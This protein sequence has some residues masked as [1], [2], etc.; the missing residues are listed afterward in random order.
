MN[1]LDGKVIAVTGASGIAAAAARRFASAGARVQLFSLHE[2]E[3]AAVAAEL[4]DGGTE[5]FWAAVD[6]TDGDATEAAFGEGR[7]RLG[8]L[9]GLFAVAGGSGRRFGDGPLHEASTEGWRTTMDLNGLP[10]FHA[11]RAAVR[12]M[13][14]EPGPGSIVLISSVLATDPSPRLFPTHAYAAAKGGTLSLVKAAASY[15]APNGIRFNAI[16]PGLVDTPMAARAATDPDTLEYAR[17]KQ[18]LAGGL[19]DPADIAAAAV[20]LLSD[21]SRMVTGQVLAV[22]GGWSVAEVG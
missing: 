12:I 22:D 13:L 21:D 2:A 20:F 8:R 14:E 7:A 10:A 18:P 5:T 3:A 4:A 1:S 11:A 6:L 19:L 17:R 16:A 15:Y 9:D